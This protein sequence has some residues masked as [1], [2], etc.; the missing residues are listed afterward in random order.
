MCESK[1]LERF[2]AVTRNSVYRVVAYGEENCPFIEKIASIK[3]R[4]DLPIGTKLNN[5]KMLAVADYLQLY[6]LD[7]EQRQLEFVSGKYWGAHTSWIV[8]L[9]LTEEEALFCSEQPDLRACDERWIDKT[10]EVVERIGADHP[11]VTICH[12]KDF[13]L[14]PVNSAEAE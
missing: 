14:L 3:E 6:D 1:H 8:A 2:F 13:T 9:F 10:K 4:S 11:N 12:F 5:R 7:H